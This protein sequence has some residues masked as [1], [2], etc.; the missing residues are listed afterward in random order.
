[1]K[2]IGFIINPVAGIG[3]KVGL[4]G[5]DGVRTLHKALELGAVPEAGAKALG[6]MKLLEPMAQQFKIYTCPGEMGGDICKKAGLN[7]QIVQG[8]ISSRLSPDSSRGTT[9]EDTIK[10]AGMLCKEG[11][12][13]ILFAGG[14]GTARN[15]LDAVGTSVPVLGIPAGCKIHSAVYARTPKA[16]GE[17]MVRYVEGRVMEYRE[18]EV[19]DI[20]EDL[21][22]QGI[23]D[24][25]LYGYL[26]VPNEKKF[27]QNLKSGRGYSEDASIQSMC[28]YVSQQIEQEPEYLYIVGTGST[29]ARLMKYMEKPNTLLGVDLLYQGQVIQSDCTEQDILAALKQYP[30]AKIIV[31]VIG[32]QGYIF[33]RGNQQ[34]SAEVIRRVGTKNIM[35]IASRD[36]IFSLGGN[37]LLIDTGDEE[38]NQQLTGYIPVTTG[39]KDVIMAKVIY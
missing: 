5:S 32:G 12:D 8:T 19:M 33:G 2:K 13:L 23:C 3:G 10:A 26:K 34:I 16:A 37:P 9:P 6:T 39:Y 31:T 30:R 36:K 21:F 38:I 1:M 28:M 4:K 7:Y 15:I 11:V 27:V 14:D 25:R 29:T 18:A 24:A 35:V 20:D 17:L 22:R